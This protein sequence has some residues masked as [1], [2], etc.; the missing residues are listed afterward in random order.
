[1]VVIGIDEVGRGCLAGPVVAGAVILSQAIPGVKDSKLLSRAQRQKLDQIIR[2][3]AALVGLGWASASEI[4]QLGLTAALRL[5]M[6][7]AVA[8]L[9][10]VD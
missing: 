2:R 5:A 7:R 8:D 9:G 3:S 6:E 1:M 4:D 10:Q